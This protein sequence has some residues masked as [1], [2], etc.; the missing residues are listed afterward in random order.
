MMSYSA[1]HLCAALLSAQP[2]ILCLSSC[3]VRAK[4][5][6][7]ASLM[8]SLN[9]THSHPAWLHCSDSIRNCT[10]VQRLKLRL[11]RRSRSFRATLTEK[12]WF[13]FRFV[14]YFIGLEQLVTIATGSRWPGLLSM[15]V[16]A[17]VCDVKTKLDILY[18]CRPLPHG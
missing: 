3:H 1:T 2:P 12:I 18:S 10:L 6:A 8:T 13:S 15:F 9:P 4:H 17:G 14:L 16:S 7:S 11:R 5:M